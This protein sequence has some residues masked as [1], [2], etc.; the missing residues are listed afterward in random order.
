MKRIFAVV[1][2]AP[3]LALFAGVGTLAF[4]VAGKWD[5]RNTDVLI[6]N[7]TMICGV[8]GLVLAL[9]LSAFVGLVF[10]SRWQKDHHWST[11]PMWSNPR[12]RQVPQATPPQLPAWMDGPP[13][14]TGDATPKGRLYSAGPGTYED[15]DDTL[16]GDSQSIQTEWSEIP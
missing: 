6:T 12:V 10:Y 3:I 2:A 5:E 7:L 9:V 8:A 16:F 1:V 14:L 15:L 13:P 4:S 11:P